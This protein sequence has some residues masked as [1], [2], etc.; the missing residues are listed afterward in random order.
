MAFRLCGIPA[1]D[2]SLACRTLAYD[3]NRGNLGKRNPRS[4]WR[5]RPLPCLQSVK[6]EPRWASSR[7]SS[8]T[9]TNLPKSTVVSVGI[10]DHPGG[11]FAAGGLNTGVLFDSI[12]TSES[13]NSLLR[14]AAFR[15][16]HCRAGAGARRGLD[17]RTNLL[18]NRWTPDGG[19][20]R[21][22]VSPGTG[23]Q[24]RHC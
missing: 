8:A 20:G 7:R 5:A 23:R 17:R 3:L 22:V 15:S 14:R 11:A 13:L 19:C 10:H 24:C 6:A 4:R 18:S 21:G 12:G 9:A 2:P 1:T 16:S